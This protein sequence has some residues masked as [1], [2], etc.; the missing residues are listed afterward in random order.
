MTEAVTDTEAL[1]VEESED[2]PPPKPP[3]EVKVGARD[4]V[5]WRA[6]EGVGGTV[7]DSGGDGEGSGE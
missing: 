4:P 2:P 1:A 5:E 3:P 7:G 6:R